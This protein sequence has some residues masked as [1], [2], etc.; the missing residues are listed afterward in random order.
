M[1]VWLP[2]SPVEGTDH[3]WNWWKN[4]MSAFL[5]KRMPVSWLVREVGVLQSCGFQVPNRGLNRAGGFVL[6]LWWKFSRLRNWNSCVGCNCADAG[7]SQRLPGCSD[8]SRQ[9]PYHHRSVLHRGWGA[10]SRRGRHHQGPGRTGRHLASGAPEQRVGVAEKE[11]PRMGVLSE[12][13]L[14]LLPSSF[15]WYRVETNF[16]HWRPP[17]SRD[18]RR[19][20]SSTCCKLTSLHESCWLYCDDAL[21]R[22]EA[23]NIAL[24]V[25]GQDHIN[26]ETL[27]QASPEQVG[28][29][30][31]AEA[32]V[33][34]PPFEPD[35]RDTAFRLQNKLCC[36][37][38]TF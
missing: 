36:T 24:N 27:Y 20:D 1:G 32:H 11:D 35:S 15:S 6:A 10:S 8:A 29:V 19:W 38:L 7:R 9:N 26:L 2:A 30:P 12:C 22:R 23:A 31:G 25:T 5:F 14:K 4:V 37:F 33:M 21:G 13:R 16:D 18:H 3:W 28:C 34:P 17:P